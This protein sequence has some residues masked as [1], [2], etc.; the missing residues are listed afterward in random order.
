MAYGHVARP[1]PMPRNAGWVYEDEAD[2]ESTQAAQGAGAWTQDPWATMG[3]MGGMMGLITLCV[4]LVARGVQ[5]M[6]GSGHYAR[7]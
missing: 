6:M 1:R 2:G 3:C 5:E 4:M 7:S